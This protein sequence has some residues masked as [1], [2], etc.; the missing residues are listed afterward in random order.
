MRKGER[1][2]ISLIVNKSYD[3]V[4][5]VYS[6]VQPFQVAHRECREV[7]TVLCANKLGAIT[8]D[9]AKMTRP[10]PAHYSCADV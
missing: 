9:I 1:P 8:G 10:W 2:G 5:G 4:M 7:V 3:L 6:T